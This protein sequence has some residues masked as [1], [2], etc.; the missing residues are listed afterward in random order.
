M[1]RRPQN[2]TEGLQG[3]RQGNAGPAGPLGPWAQPGPVA[4]LGTS[5]LSLLLHPDYCT[6]SS[7]PPLCWEAGSE[8]GLRAPGAWQGQ[9]EQPSPRP[10][11]VHTTV[12]PA[13]LALGLSH[14]E[15]AGVSPGT[16][17]L[18]VSQPALTHCWLPSPFCFLA[19]FQH[20][21]PRMATQV[22]SLV[23][24]LPVR[25]EDAGAPVPNRPPASAGRPLAP[26][27]LCA[28]GLLCT[29][30]FPPTKRPQATSQ[31]K[32]GSQRSR[33]RVHTLT[34]PHMGPKVGWSAKA[35]TQPRLARQQEDTQTLLPGGGPGPGTSLHTE[36]SWALA[37]PR[38]PLGRHAPAS[39]GAPPSIPRH[40]GRCGSP[41]C[42]LFHSCD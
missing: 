31:G 34:P 18:P 17:M 5:S 10:P 21:F 33:P 26:C 39:L 25:P 28:Q 14:A 24:L 8:R 29:D 35:H 37:S 30:S 40:R 23:P 15:E 3:L 27:G 36:Q 6:A 16:C 9:A 19:C 7:G 1:D 22:N 12:A 20:P 2:S 32:S 11:R 41:V 4:G 42:G 13:R 38:H